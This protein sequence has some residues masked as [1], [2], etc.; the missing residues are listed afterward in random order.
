MKLDLGPSRPGYVTPVFGTQEI[1]PLDPRLE[2]RLRRPMIVGGA[3]IGVL[4]VGLGLWAS[5]TPLA[6][7]VSAMGE[8]EVESNLKTLRHKEGGVVRQILVQ[9]GQLVR[10]NQPLIRLDETSRGRRWTCCRTRP[11]P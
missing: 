6:S 2:Q 7:G 11:T 10:A 4:V 8:V 5:L 3:I 1:E 9:E